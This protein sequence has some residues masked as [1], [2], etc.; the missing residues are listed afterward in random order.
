MNIDFV[1]TA[2][3]AMADKGEKELSYG[4]A[5]GAATLQKAAKQ[6][7]TAAEADPSRKDELI[8]LAE[9]C[10][11][12]A[13]NP[14]AAAPGPSNPQRPA[15][16]ARPSAPQRP[17]TPPTPNG[18]PRANSQSENK[19]EVTA[20]VEEASEDISAEEAMERLNS[21][22]GLT[23][24]KKQVQ[25]YVSQMRV[26]S[27]RERLNLPVPKDFSYHLVFTGNPGTGK[28]TVAR[29]MGQ[30]Y[31]ALGILEKGH[32]VEASSSDLVAGYVGQTAP[33]TR[34]LVETALGGVLFVDE[35]YT[36][37]GNEK[38][39]EFGKQ[40][41]DELL[42][43]M[44][45]YRRELIVVI[46]G[47]CEPMK[48]LLLTNPGLQSRFNTTI[49]FEDYTADE[50]MSIFNGLCSKNEYNLSSGSQ[51]MLQSY[52]KKLYEGRDENFGNGRTVRNTF[53][54]IVQSQAVRLDKMM[55]KMAAG[56]ATREMFTLINEEDVANAIGEGKDMSAEYMR[57]KKETD[58][59]VIFNY[60][61]Q[62]NLTSASIALCSRLESLL[63]HVYGYQGELYE[64]INQL[65][66]SGGE[67]ARLLKK[68]DYDCLYR[69]RTY[70]NA[71]IHSGKDEVDLTP[72]DI[73]DGLKIIS[74]LE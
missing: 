70:R 32:L 47:Y 65:R 67:R 34:A 7:R 60:L 59:S 45:D 28:T 61:A 14:P 37:N 53:Q 13:G 38:G 51:F 39:N 35:A 1:I 11:Q 3:K 12:K 49:E 9:A 68:Q 56:E 57:T 64:M 23:T 66:S 5:S 72:Q 33:K 74:S 21:L 31:K 52:F 55:S 29:L 25:T 15:T 8:A 62:S 63:K 48:E 69:I 10:E 18:T 6:Y 54:R 27:E 41:I 17:G 40:A 42:K 44:E 20:R 26:F 71:H 73:L 16:P 36:L 4:M 24:V 46:A 19:P 2:A 22:T 50:L 58:D 43:C 30:I